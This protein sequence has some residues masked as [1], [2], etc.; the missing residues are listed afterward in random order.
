MFYLKHKNS[1]IS[2]VYLHYRKGKNKNII[3]MKYFPGINVVVADWNPGT[4]RLNEVT[5]DRRTY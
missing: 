5:K 1:D 3:N 4:Q 2:P